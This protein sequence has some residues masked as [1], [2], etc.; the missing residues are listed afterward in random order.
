MQ[1][2]KGKQN[3]EKKKNTSWSIDLLFIKEKW[4]SWRN[5]VQRKNSCESNNAKGLKKKQKKFYSAYLLKRRG[6]GFL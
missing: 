3:K 2:E 6:F 1:K 4:Q 5:L